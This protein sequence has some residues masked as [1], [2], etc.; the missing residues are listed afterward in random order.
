MCPI[1]YSEEKKKRLLSLT[2]TLLR[3]DSCL[4]QCSAFIS[5]TSKTLELH[6]NAISW[7]DAMES[8][9]YDSISMQ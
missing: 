3:K 5:Q 2:T 8:S 6:Y 4:L 9:F 1:I 7:L